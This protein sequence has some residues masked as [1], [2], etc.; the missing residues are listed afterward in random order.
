MLSILDVVLRRGTFAVEPK[1]DGL[2]A[3]MKHVFIRGG[4]D[5]REGFGI[6]DFINIELHRIADLLQRGQSNGSS[7]FSPVKSH[8]TD[9]RFRGEF[10]LSEPR[11]QP[12]RIEVLADQTPVDRRGDAAIFFS[13]IEDYM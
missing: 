12:P 7:R 9:L 4:L 2:I 10:L 1:P 11:D 13:H 6:Q 8:R 5:V 3:G